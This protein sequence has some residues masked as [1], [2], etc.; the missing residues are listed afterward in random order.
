MA[1]IPEQAARKVAGVVW[2][3][4]WLWPLITPALSVAS[5]QTH[6]VLPA[7]AGL[8]GF[9]VTYVVVV[10]T[11]FSRDGLPPTRLQLAGLVMTAVLG[12]ATAVGYG[13]MNSGWHSTLLYV[14]E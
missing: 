13:R 11:A 12:L 14:G 2:T 7:A 4:L 10:V 6:P 3:A 8:A 1:R 9:V 5:G